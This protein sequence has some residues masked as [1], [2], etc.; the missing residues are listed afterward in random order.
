MQAT[1]WPARPTRRQVAALLELIDPPFYKGRHQDV[2]VGAHLHAQA[3]CIW[4]QLKLA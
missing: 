3:H 1:D 4:Q 2:Q